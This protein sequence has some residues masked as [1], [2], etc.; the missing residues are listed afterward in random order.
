MN[1]LDNFRRSRAT[2][3]ALALAALAACASGKKITQMEP[4]KPHQS[5]VFG[6]ELIDAIAALP[7]PVSCNVLLDAVRGALQKA[8]A[9]STLRGKCG[10]VC[11]ELHDFPDNETRV[12]LRLLDIGEV[13]GRHL[14]DVV[15]ERPKTKQDPPGVLNLGINKI[16]VD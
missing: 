9:V 16:C 2:V 8:G 3:P 13:Q 5:L 11:H 1:T 7:S 14:L 15:I 10:L 12:L 4:P 6:H